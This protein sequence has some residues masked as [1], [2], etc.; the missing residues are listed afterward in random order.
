MPVSSLLL[1]IDPAHEAALRARLVD[2]ARTTLGPTIG[3]RLVVALDTASRADDE[4][5]W[6]W[7]HALPGVR[8]IDLVWISIDPTE[9]NEG[10]EPRRRS[11]EQESRHERRSA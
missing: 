3:T 7:L 8:F 9:D 10:R 2:D 4:V 5:A 6:A 1:T 11:N